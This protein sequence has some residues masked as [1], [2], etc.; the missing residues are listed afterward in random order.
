MPKYKFSEIR[1]PHGCSPV[2][3]LHIFKAHFPKNTSRRLLLDSL[4]PFIQVNSK[5]CC[6]LNPFRKPH[7][8]VEGILSNY[9]EGCLLINFSNTLNITF[10][11]NVDWSVI[12]FLIST[13]FFKNR[14]CISAF[15]R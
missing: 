11:K 7:R 14:S 1:L 9:V 2:N 12:L 15:Q 13:A 6:V 8:N 4:L 5:L 10:W 3:L